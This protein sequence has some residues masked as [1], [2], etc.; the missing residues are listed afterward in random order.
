MSPSAS[1][2][3]RV[4]DKPAVVVTEDP[5]VSEM[6]PAVSVDRAGELLKLETLMAFPVKSAISMDVSA[7]GTQSSAAPML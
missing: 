3:E 4:P 2:A 6:E 1:V 7:P 5:W